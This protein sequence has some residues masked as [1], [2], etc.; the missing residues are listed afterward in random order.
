[1]AT[2]FTFSNTSDDKQVEYTNWS[3]V[4]QDAKESQELSIFIDSETDIDDFIV[5]QV[6]PTYEQEYNIKINVETGHLSGVQQNLINDKL[7]GSKQ[8]KYDIV[9]LSDEPMGRSIEHLELLHSN[10]SKN[11]DRRKL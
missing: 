2:V 9:I 7:G 4:L 1:M 5:K 3:N 10:G 6:I 11:V 8:G